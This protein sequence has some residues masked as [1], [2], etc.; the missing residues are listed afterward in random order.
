MSAPAANK[1]GRSETFA[2]AISFLTGLRTYQDERTRKNN[3]EPNIDSFV[4]DFFNS[5]NKFLLKE[6]GIRNIMPYKMVGRT[7]FEPVTN[8]LKAN[9]STS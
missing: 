6:V 5:L 2:T 1:Y 4:K 9:C 7:G 8:W 3:K